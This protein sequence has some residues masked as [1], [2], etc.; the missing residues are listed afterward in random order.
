MLS[1]HRLTAFIYLLV[2]ILVGTSVGRV[3]FLGAR[4][5]GFIWAL[6]LVLVTVHYLPK[7]RKYPLVW[8]SSLAFSKDCRLKSLSGDA[9]S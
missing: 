3:W 7:K 4:S 1:Y 9:I 5:A 8:T 6:G 2:N